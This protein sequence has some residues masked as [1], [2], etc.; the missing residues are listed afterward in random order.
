MRAKRLLAIIV[1][2]LFLISLLGACN[3]WKTAGVTSV[4]DVQDHTVIE[5]GQ[6]QS[7]IVNHLFICFPPFALSKDPLVRDSPS[8]KAYR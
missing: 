3:S 5:T 4:S 7:K 6:Q 8:V 2:P 1:V